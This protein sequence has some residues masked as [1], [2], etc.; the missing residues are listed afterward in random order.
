MSMIKYAVGA[1]IAAA[2]VSSAYAFDASDH[3][4]TGTVQ[5]YI[6]GSTAVDNTLI[7]TSTAL[8][9]DSNGHEVGI[10]ANTDGAGNAN[11][12]IDIYYFGT[13]NR[14]TTCTGAANLPAG[15]AG[16]PIAIYKE[17]TVGSF[18]G[19][20]PLVGLGTAATTDGSTPTG[21]QLIFLNA[22]TPGTSGSS[23]LN[24]TNCPASGKQLANVGPTGVNDPN[25]LNYWSHT[26]T[27]ADGHLQIAANP[28]GGIADVEANLLKNPNGVFFPAAA[29]SLLTGA[30]G[31][32]VVWTP[33]VTK[34]LYY[35]LQAAQ[36]LADGTVKAACNTANNDAPAC[37]PSLS[38]SQ[39]ADIMT[40]AGFY[41]WNQILNL[42]NATDNTVYLC[43]RDD[44][45]GTEASY[46]VYFLGARCGGPSN[47]SGSKLVIATP[48]SAPGQ[49]TVNGST[50]GVRNCLQTYF[51]AG[52]W[53]LGFGAETVAADLTVH[54][55][56]TCN[57]C[58]RAPA[59]DG[60]LP[61]LANVVNGYD[62]Y[63]STDF[64][65]T[66]NSGPDKSS[67]APLTLFQSF[68][69]KLGHP[70][71]TAVTNKAFAGRPWGDSGDLSPALVYENANPPTMPAT[72]GSGGTIAANPVNAQTKGQDAGSLTNCSTPTLFNDFVN[73]N[74]LNI[75][76]DSNAL[77]SGNVNGL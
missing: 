22:G 57:D 74:P 23:H 3:L 1:A 25:F 37:A 12:S 17:S 34:N 31:L 52:Q 61:T 8:V 55:T 71:T 46:E 27:D 49:V 77:Q 35:A 69:G 65:Y 70:A 47:P 9:N 14:V 72:S 39:V 20:G 40:L 16:Q 60:V 2:G 53:A 24:L 51:A 10:C 75:P 63:W 45:S 68:E 56:N 19:P 33:W 6:G 4:P 43:R 50:G 18:N 76:L 15:L 5:L 32:D 41:S 44:G 42:N 7:V 54:G 73:P 64:L 66:A 29:L 62:P 48:A 58:F 36:H 13:S 59:I 30:P 11:P 21:Y 26:C 28:T 38:K 67:G